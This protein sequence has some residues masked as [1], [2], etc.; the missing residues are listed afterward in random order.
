M[1]NVTELEVGEAMARLSRAGRALLD[2]T[3]EDLAERAGISVSG[4]RKYEGCVATTVGMTNTLKVTFAAA[5]VELTL[6]QE[7]GQT[8]LTAS[9]RLSSGVSGAKKAPKK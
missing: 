6:S 3:Q 4:L 5:G 1:K 2:W 9:L 7:P 8:E